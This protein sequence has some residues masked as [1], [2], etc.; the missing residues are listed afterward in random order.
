LIWFYLHYPLL[1][2]QLRACVAGQTFERTLREGLFRQT[3]AP[4]LEKKKKKNQANAQDFFFFFFVG[5]IARTEKINGPFL[6]D[7]ETPH[8]ITQI[9]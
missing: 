6:R 1:R 4:H 5:L 8:P 2:I 9:E 3:P 7:L